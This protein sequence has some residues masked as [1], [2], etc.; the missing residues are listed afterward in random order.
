MCFWYVED[1]V[2]VWVTGSDKINLR[3]SSEKGTDDALE[4]P[5]VVFADMS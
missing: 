4:N 1:I 5:E 3:V 2:N